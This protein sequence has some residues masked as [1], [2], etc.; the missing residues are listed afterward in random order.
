M[1]G[2]RSTDN[3]FEAGCGRQSRQSTWGASTCGS[4]KRELWAVDIMWGWGGCPL[5]PF[6][7]WGELVGVSRW[8]EIAIRR[9]M[10]KESPEM[11]FG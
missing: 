2:W 4:Q 11:E 8:I 3:R 1:V 6:Y 7:G 10:A 5:W 9:R